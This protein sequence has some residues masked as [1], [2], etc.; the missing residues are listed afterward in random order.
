MEHSRGA[1]GL[2]GAGRRRGNGVLAIAVAAATVLAGAAQLPRHDAAAA[3]ARQVEKLNRGLVSVRSGSG[4]FVS[5]RLLGTDSSSVAFNLYRGSTKVNSSPITN[6][7]N[8]YDSGAAAGAA[9]TVR[10]VVNGAEQAASESALQFTNGHLDV[11]ISPP[12]GG[13]TPDGVSYTYS[14]NDANVGDLD[15]DGQYEIV[16]PRCQIPREL[17]YLRTVAGTDID[18]GCGGDG[19]SALP[20]RRLGP[21]RE[22]GRDRNGPRV[23]ARIAGRLPRSSPGM[24]RSPASRCT[25]RLHTTEGSAR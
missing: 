9:Y 1:G 21:A 5:W 25:P 6:S 12:S 17:R 15:G 3:T 7:T 22:R 13:T 8:Y 11:P 20:A 18:L 4:N 19:R 23:G 24:C 14:A 16:G 2:R 10:P